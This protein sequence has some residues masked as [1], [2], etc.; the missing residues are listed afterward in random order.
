MDRRDLLKAILGSS[1]ASLSTGCRG[2]SPLPPAGELLAPNHHVGHQ[3]RDGMNFQATAS[4][5][6][7]VG[8]VIVGGG[9]AGLS[10]AWQ[11]KRSGYDD[12]VLL[13]MEDRLGGTSASGKD[14]N[15]EY[16][17]GAHYVPVPMAHNRELIELLDEMGV[18]ESISADGAPTIKEQFLCR[19][20]EERV[21]AD[22][23]WTEGLYPTK[24]ATD[25]D[26]AQLATFRTEIDR[27]VDRLDSSGRRMFAIPMA[28]GSDTEEVRQLD[29]VSMA[30]WM[31]EK[32][33]TSKRLRWLVDYACRDDFGLT[34]EHTSAWAGLFYFASRVQRVGD[35]SQEVITWPAGNGEIIKHLSSCVAPAIRSSHAV[36]E[37][38]EDTD[39]D[40]VLV[41]AFSTKAKSTLGFKSQRVIFATPQFLAPYIVKGFKESR[42]VSAFQYGGWVVANLHLRDRPINEGFASCWDNVLYDSKSLGY[43]VSTHQTG[44]DHGPT[45]VTWYYPMAATDPRV[46]R[47]QLLEL[48]WSHWAEIILSDLEVAHPSIRKLTAKLDIMRWGHAMIQPRPGFVWSQQRLDAAKPFGRV[49]FANTDLSGIALMEEAFYHGVRSAREVLSFA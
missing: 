45:V 32:K 1:L 36:L 42:D 14:A 22:G 21:F 46:S 23:Q 27:W 8:C 43:V 44:N 2:R 11:L 6:Q 47:Q 17:W 7:D 39:H 9:I 29:S 38:R 15:F 28:T 19:D 24:G 40:Q 26:L 34:L 31:N 13:E 5:W 41:T 3:I 16:P 30:D 35:D 20:P 10:A 18:V 4:D 49:H 37:V 33:F 48:D 25:D 12:F